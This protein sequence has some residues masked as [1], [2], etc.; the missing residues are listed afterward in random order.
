MKVT[1]YLTLTDQLLRAGNLFY[2][3]ISSTSHCIWNVG[4]T[5]QISPN[6]INYKWWGNYCKN[7]SSKVVGMLLSPW[8]IIVKGNT[9]M[10]NLWVFAWTSVCFGDATHGTLQ[11]LVLV[12]CSQITPGGSH[13]PY[14]MPGSNSDQK[15]TRWMPYSLYYCSSP[16]FFLYYKKK[17]LC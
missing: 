2:P 14:E 9:V 8:D 4:S 3:F 12:L 7:S 13:E 1:A 11:G 5:Q 17:I 6:W 15:Q 10:A 16:N